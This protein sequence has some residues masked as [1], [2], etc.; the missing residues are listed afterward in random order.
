MEQMVFVCTTQSHEDEIWPIHKHVLKTKGTTA[1]TSLLKVMTA[2]FLSDLSPCVDLCCWT[3]RFSSA[4]EQS[5]ASRLLKRHRRR[6]KQRPP[7]LERV[8]TDLH[9]LYL[10]YWFTVSSGSFKSGCYSWL[11]VVS[12]WISHLKQRTYL[13]I[14]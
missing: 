5:T 4:T 9:L 14:S 6:R 12:Y 3:C 11:I 2:C 13:C 7:R 10:C 1:A 8:R